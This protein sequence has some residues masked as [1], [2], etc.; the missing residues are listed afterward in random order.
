MTGGEIVA[1]TIADL[2]IAISWVGLAAYAISEIRR[3][4]RKSSN[5]N[6]KEQ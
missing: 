1:A 6:D 2:I 3:L 4:R 5:D